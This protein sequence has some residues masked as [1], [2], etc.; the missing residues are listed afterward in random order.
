[1]TSKQC[2]LQVLAGPTALFQLKIKVIKTQTPTLK[3]PTFDHFWTEFLQFAS[4]KNPP[5]HQYHGTSPTRPPVTLTLHSLFEGIEFFRPFPPELVRNAP[6]GVV[7]SA[8]VSPSQGS[9]G[10]SAD[11]R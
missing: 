2:F 5:A 6:K 1:M 4:Q 8:C 10:S 3:T 7:G 9:I 11:M